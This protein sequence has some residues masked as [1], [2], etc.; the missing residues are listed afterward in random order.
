M[1][2]KLSPKTKEELQA[3]IE[4]LRQEVDSLKRANAQYQ[5]EPVAL[6]QNYFRAIFDQSPFSIQIYGL[7]GKL[8]EM[9]EA[10]EKLWEVTYK[11]I[12]HYNVLEDQQIYALGI[13]PYF[14]RAFSGELVTLPPTF[15]DPSKT[16]PGHPGRP[17]W[18]EARICPIKDSQGKIVQ[19]ALVHNDITEKKLAENALQAAYGDLEVSVIK[20]T[21]ELSQANA[22]LKKQLQ[23]LKVAAEEREIL[24]LVLENIP[25]MINYYDENR[26][27]LLVN[28]EWEKT[29]GWTFEKLKKEGAE[30]FVKSIFPDLE[31][32][33]RIYEMMMDPLP[34][35]YDV[36]VVLEN[37]KTL[38]TS[39]VTR[40]LSNG[41]TI[42][43]GRDISE[44][45]RAESALQKSEATLRTI[46]ESATDAIFIKDLQGKYLLI[47]SAG[48][49]F[50]GKT[51]EEVIGKDDREFFSLDTAE[52]IMAGDRLVITSNQTHSYEDIGTAAGVTRTYLSI[53]TPYHDSEG[54]V[55]GLIGISREI[56]ERKRVEE[57]IAAE[58]KLLAVTLGS[59]KDGV[60]T[61][62]K[63]GT[64]VLINQAAE[65]IIG[66]NQEETINKPFN[67]ILKLVSESDR[68]TRRNTINR[69]LKTGKRIEHTTASILIT[70]DGQERI[71]SESALPIFDTDSNLIGVVLVFR[72]I[73][74]KRKIEEKLMHEQAARAVAK[75]VELELEKSNLQLQALSAY[76]LKAQEEERIR[77]A[78]ELHDELGQALTSIRLGLELATASLPETHT[79]KTN[80]ILNDLCA[81]VETTA[82]DVQRVA[83]DL[84][85]S[86]LDDFGLAAAL[87]AYADAYAK[88]T[89]IRVTLSL[90]KL[91]KPLTKEVE[92]AFYR[93]VQEALNNSAKHSAAKNI[94]IDFIEQH[95]QIVLTI[96]DDGKG[97]VLDI[98]Q[99]NSFGLMG[100]SERARIVGAE[101]SMKS[102][103]GKG[104]WIQVTLPKGKT[105]NYEKI[106]NIISR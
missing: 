85:P 97:C 70:K 87:E 82:K 71:V 44:S 57:A 39:W 20:R 31:E 67:K 50:L 26:E 1:S 80:K 49:R 42:C 83:R 6:S 99:K 56:T 5:K 102:Q 104:F 45:K 35:W 40:K 30:K 43:I 9:N 38:E 106:K 101:I 54:K 86:V 75:L 74:E 103:V 25:L 91:L 55:I 95:T 34:Y 79:N 58:K 59:I 19:I 81:Y 65:Q 37:G 14:K 27:F 73:T 84:R 24:H 62:D 36:K 63:E 29:F 78:R 69:A 68:K 105:G 77:L 98:E 96:V 64:I 60:I 53:K 52:E 93:I 72:D 2:T 7:N 90:D 11:E 3:E 22:Q 28:K 76:V 47:N 92:T 66:V 94:S 48:A 41:K 46:I 17:R 89:G 13:M 12:S 88:R 100:M 33:K 51:V 21:K 16:L 61:V 18:V 15:Y 23:E 32:Q 10:S 4:L 8:L